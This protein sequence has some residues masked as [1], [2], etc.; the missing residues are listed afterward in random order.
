MPFSGVLNITCRAKGSP[1]PK[2]G[3]WK[4]HSKESALIATGNDENGAQLMI[5]HPSEKNFG[6]YSCVAENW[7]KEELILHLRKGT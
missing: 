1:F 3:W 5:T 7:H 6:K 4:L 2:I